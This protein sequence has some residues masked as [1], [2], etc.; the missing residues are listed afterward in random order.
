MLNIDKLVVHYQKLQIIKGISFEVPHGNGIL[1]QD[2]RLRVDRVVKS[3]T[4][5]LHTFRNEMI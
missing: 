5:L 1:L 4:P 2:S 3:L